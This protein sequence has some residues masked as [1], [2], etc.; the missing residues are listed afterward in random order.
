MSL[1]VNTKLDTRISHYQ[2]AK[3]P[4]C[5]NLLELIRTLS[6]SFLIQDSQATYHE[7]SVCGNEVVCN[8]RKM[9]KNYDALDGVFDYL[10][11]NR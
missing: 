4:I 2:I 5:F 3:R 9:S 6:C 10:Y 1:S 11:S 8:E 7:F